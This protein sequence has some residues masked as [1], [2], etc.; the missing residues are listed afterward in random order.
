MTKREGNRKRNVARGSR[1]LFE[2]G[3]FFRP[4]GALSILGSTPAVETAGYFLPRLRR[5][6]GGVCRAKDAKAA[7]EAQNIQWLVGG[8]VRRD[9][10]HGARDARAPQR[11]ISVS[12]SAIGISAPRQTWLAGSEHDLLLIV[13][14]KEKPGLDPTV[15]GLY[16]KSRCF[17]RDAGNCARDARAP[18]RPISVPINDMKITIFSEAKMGRNFNR[19]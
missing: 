2:R 16:R 12:I 17:R 7:K 18:Q 8:C 1:R 4:F 11:L 9:A 3:S 5:Y 13:R 14:S 10:E 19:K 15:A 6:R